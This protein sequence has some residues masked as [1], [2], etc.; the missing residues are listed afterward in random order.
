MKVCQNCGT[1]CQ[2][3][4]LYCQACGSPLNTQPKAAVH[5]ITIRRPCQLIGCACEMYIT[6]DDKSRY[7]LKNSGSIR[8]LVSP[9]QH[10]IKISGGFHLSHECTLYVS[11]DMFLEC[12]F[13]SG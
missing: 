1:Q 12:T 3:F 13:K 4:Q 5:T 7:G 2:D 8:M 9:G 6:L 10:D 11:E